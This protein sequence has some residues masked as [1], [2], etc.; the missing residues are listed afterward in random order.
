MN[1]FTLKAI[2]VT[3]HQARIMLLET[4]TVNF[5]LQNE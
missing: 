1:L 3:F 2:E 4:G 5:A